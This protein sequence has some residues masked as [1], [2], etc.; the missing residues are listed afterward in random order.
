MTCPGP[1]LG[2]DMHVA[3]DTRFTKD[4]KRVQRDWATWDL[5]AMPLKICPVIR[6]DTSRPVDIAP[7]TRLVR[8]VICPA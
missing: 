2:N 7:L 8:E 3:F 5:D 4:D 6:V 1:S